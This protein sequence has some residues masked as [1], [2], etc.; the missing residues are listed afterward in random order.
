[1]GR[2]AKSSVLL[3]IVLV[4]VSSPGNASFLFHSQPLEQ[5]AG[6]C[7]EHGSK[8]P[9]PQPAD[10][11]CCLT[12]HNVA[13]PQAPHSA[14]PLLQDIEAELVVQSPVTSMEAGSGKTLVSSGD[15][16]DATPLRI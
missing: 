12:G 5:P 16:P 13:V 8:A 14:E 2:F 11:Q 3:L 4:S 6:G 7:H 9:S 10:F 15:P 1:M